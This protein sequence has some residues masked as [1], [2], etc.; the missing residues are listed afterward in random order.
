M[1][2]TVLQDLFAA[3]ERTHYERI[4]AAVKAA[5]RKVALEDVEDDEEAREDA[6]EAIFHCE[7]CI[8]REVMEVIWPPVA[9]YIDWLRNQIPEVPA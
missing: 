9:D 4:D 8:V 6:F 7:T 2:D 5:E 1:S 3:A